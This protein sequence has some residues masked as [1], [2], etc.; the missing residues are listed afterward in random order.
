LERLAK[1]RH[2]RKVFLHINNT[3]PILDEDSPEHLA[4]RAA[5][6]EVACDGM[7]IAL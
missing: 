6:W 4:V 1:L 5:G 7:T 3:N 2:P